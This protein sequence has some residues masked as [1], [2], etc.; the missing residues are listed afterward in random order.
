M[1]IDSRKMTVIQECSGAEFS[2]GT[3][4]N[5]SVLLAPLKL[6]IAILGVEKNFVH[7]NIQGSVYM[8]IKKQKACNISTINSAKRE[9]KLTYKNHSEDTI[10]E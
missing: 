3:A 9:E 10:L 6:S 7:G 2:Y 8:F 4:E 1:Q 5:I